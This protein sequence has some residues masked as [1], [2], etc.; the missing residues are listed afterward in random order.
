MTKI[1]SGRG[2]PTSMA[3]VQILLA[4]TSFSDLLFYKEPNRRDSFKIG[5]FRIVVKVFGGC[6]LPKI[7][8]LEQF[9]S[10]AKTFKNTKQSS[11]F[12]QKYTLKQFV[13]L[14]YIDLSFLFQ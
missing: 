4:S 10:D 2:L 6:N 1:E 3:H 8:K 12:K 11:I 7:K 9:Y 14:T 13:A 5:K